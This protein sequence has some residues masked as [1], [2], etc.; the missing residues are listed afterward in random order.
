MTRVLIVEDEAVLRNSVV[1]GLGKIPG[2]DIIGAGSMAEALD[3]IDKAPP[4]MIVC[5]LDL[6]DRLGIEIL[7][8]L[9]RRGLRRPV[10]FVSAYL[11]AYGSQ[12][13]PHAD[14]EVMEKPVPLEILRE[15]VT[16][17]LKV[18]VTE[19]PFAIAD[20]FQLACMG[21]RSVTITL[22]NPAGGRVVVRDGHPWSAEDA[23]GDGDKAFRRMAFRRD[24][25]VECETLVGDAGPRNLFQG[26]EELV[27]EAA[28]EADEAAHKAEPRDSP[29]PGGP[30]TMPP[31][32]VSFGDDRPDPDEERFQDT[33]DRGLQALL[34]KNYAEALVAFLEARK[35]R[36]EDGKVKANL[37]RLEAM[38]IHAPQEGET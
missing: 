29:P 14:V 34:K 12:I 28:Q 31:P 2:L 17:R 26:W 7:G 27:L 24:T 20:Y 15:A 25:R 32:G 3:E 18:D 13:P 21:R 8:E 33:W 30:P 11:R 36:P 9:G 19:T 4:G 1:R 10:L 37:T 35:M 6:P 22:E 23:D 38:G 16:R 5:D